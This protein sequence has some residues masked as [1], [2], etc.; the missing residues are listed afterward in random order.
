MKKILYLAC[1]L[2]ITVACT[3]VEKADTSSTSLPAAYIEKAKKYANVVSFDTKYLS[4]IEVFALREVAYPYTQMKQM[5][6]LDAGRPHPTKIYTELGLYD[7]KSVPCLH[8]DEAAFLEKTT[9]G[10]LLKNLKPAQTNM[11]FALSHKDSIGEYQLLNIEKDVS[12]D[13][14]GA[15]VRIPG[16]REVQERL[17][18]HVR[19][20]GYS[21]FSFYGKI[22]IVAFD[23][24][25][26]AVIYNPMGEKEDLQRLCEYIEAKLKDKNP[27]GTFKSYM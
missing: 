27:D 12:R 10:N 20:A 18:E 25:G 24:T 13:L 5:P 7:I 2:P 26:R 23:E 16:W 9:P 11:T 22:Y 21:I 3:P 8:L 17:P 19:E 14:W 15:R 6:Q 1:L 4:E